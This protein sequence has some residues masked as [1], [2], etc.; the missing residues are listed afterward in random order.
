MSLAGLSRPEDNEALKDIIL[1]R[2]RDA[3]QIPFAEY[4]ALALYHPDLGYCRACDP[5]L[6]F[7]TSPEVH[8]VFGAMIGR[9]LADM[10]RLVDRPQRF[11]VFEGGAGSGR[12]CHVIVRWAMT[13]AP[14]FYACLQYL[15]CDPRLAAINDLAVSM[16]E[17][18]EHVSLAKELPVDRSITGCVLS[19]ELLDAFPFHVVRGTENGMEEMFVRAEGR[20]LQW[21]AGEPVE[22][23]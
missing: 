6:D 1:A 22:E 8:P 10:W 17:A 9:S 7:Q 12:L 14:D 4:M 11:A 5:S 3:G 23:V 19:N 16:G 15:L 21:Q 13:E 2:I 18:V 20:Q